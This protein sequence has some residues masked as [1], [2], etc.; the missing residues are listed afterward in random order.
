LLVLDVDGVLTDGRIIFDDRGAQT[1]EFNVRDGL[2]LRLLM[3][4]GIP[5]CV[6]TGRKSEALAHRC[7][8]LGIPFVLQGVA[9]KAAEMDGLLKKTGV[10]AEH[11]AYVGD[12]LVDLPAMNK[13]GIPIAVADACE[14]VVSSAEF[15]TAAKGGAGAVREICEAILK[16]KGMWRHVLERFGA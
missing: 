3:D 7:K 4:A 11:T 13:V 8:D 10:L 2:G 16:S 12:D 14:E 15:V 9:D 6:M 1:K 5:V